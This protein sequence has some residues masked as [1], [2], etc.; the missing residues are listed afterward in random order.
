MPNKAK[1]IFLLT[2]SKPTY[3][4]CMRESL[5]PTNI[6]PSE[7]RITLYDPVLTSSTR[8]MAVKSYQQS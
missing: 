7:L 1:Q 3:Y 6:S 8:M 2:K 4:L 5:T